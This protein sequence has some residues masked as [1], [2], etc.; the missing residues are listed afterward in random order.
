[1]LHEGREVT[2]GEKWIIRTD[3]C[4]KRATKSTF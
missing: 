4:I 1:M 3:V 2:D